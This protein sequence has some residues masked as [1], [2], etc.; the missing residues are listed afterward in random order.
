MAQWLAGRTAQAI[1]TFMV[2]VVLM[3]FIMR[4]TPGDPLARVVGERQITAEEYRRLQE[5]YGLDQPLVRQFSAFVGGIVRGD[6]GTSIAYA[7]A[8]VTSL[9]RARIPATL[10][11]GGTVLLVNFSL[12]ILLGVWQ[13]VH[14]GDRIDR[15]LSLLTLTAYAIPSF[16]LGLVLAWLFGINWHVL[17]NDDISSDFHPQSLP[18]ESSSRTRV[19]LYGMNISLISWK[20]PFIGS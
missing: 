2:A 17:P 9:I 5:R 16:W 12:G 14:R 1:V 15:W 7:P 4:L 18:T 11:L 8:S 6:L 3:F 19:R 20:P 13:A 10:L